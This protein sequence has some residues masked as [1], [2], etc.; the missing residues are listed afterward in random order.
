[1]VLSCNKSGSVKLMNNSHKIVVVGA[2]SVGKSSLI[3]RLVQDIFIDLTTSTTGAD[4]Y[5][6]NCIVNNE[7]TK[8]QIWDTAGQERFRSI[9]KSYFRNAV[10]AVLVFDITNSDS[11]DQLTNWLNDL[12]N[13]CSTNA[14]II[15]IGNKSDLVEQR[16]IGESLIQDFAT[17][18]QLHYV[19]TSAKTGA[20]IKEAFSKLANEV[21]IRKKSGIIPED[22]RPTAKLSPN[23]AKQDNSS[24][25]C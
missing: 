17:R 3:K 15:L 8:L 7:D 19:E 14:Y 4:Y 16:Q 18:H 24:M 9:S 1:M 2:S 5:S 20:N 10:G 22:T 21:V 6:Y 23:I 25:C 13:L 11:F 12:H